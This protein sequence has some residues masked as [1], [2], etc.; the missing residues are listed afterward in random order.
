LDSYLFGVESI[1]PLSELRIESIKP[2]T[3]KAN[4]DNVAWHSGLHQCQ[5]ARIRISLH[6]EKVLV[7]IEIA[8]K[9]KV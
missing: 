2:E 3:K 9:S 5:E 8:L 6:Q 7:T 4:L 1:I